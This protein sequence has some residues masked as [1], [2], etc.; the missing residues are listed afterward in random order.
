MP[1]HW[2]VGPRSTSSCPSLHRGPRPSA[3]VLFIKMA[4]N[5]AQSKPPTNLLAFLSWES[6]NITET[7][8]PNLLLTINTF[9]FRSSCIEEVKSAKNWGRK[10]RKKK[11]NERGK[12][13][14]VR[15]QAVSF[16]QI[17]RMGPSTKS[18]PFK[19]FPEFSSSDESWLWISTSLLNSSKR[20]WRGL[21]L[22]KLWSFKRALWISVQNLF[23]MGNLNW[24]F[25]SESLSGGKIRSFVSS[26]D[27]LVPKCEYCLIRFCPMFLEIKLHHPFDFQNIDLK[28]QL[29]VCGSFDWGRWSWDQSLMVI[30]LFEQRYSWKLAEIFK[31]PS[32]IQE[33]CFLLI[34]LMLPF[35]ILGSLFNMQW[36]LE[37]VIV[38]E[39]MGFNPFSNL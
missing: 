34:N 8:L 20:Q 5:G 22:V 7:P 3:A 32:L 1:T 28:P 15:F 33:A 36:V 19:P 14:W 30:A 4:P 17:R 25:L 16:F 23:L 29:C 13:G 27:I 35:L 12:K 11:T 9:Y 31:L 6:P 18:L 10:G 24:V 39:E 26:F 2:H 38:T 21:R 37:P